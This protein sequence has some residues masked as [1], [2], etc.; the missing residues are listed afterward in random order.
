MQPPNQKGSQWGDK[1]TYL[2]SPR[3]NHCVLKSMCSWRW[4]WDTGETANS[5]VYNPFDKGGKHAVPCVKGPSRLWLE[6]KVGQGVSTGSGAGIRTGHLGTWHFPVI[7]VSH[8]GAEVQSAHP[9]VHQLYLNETGGKKNAHSPSG[10]WPPRIGPNAFPKPDLHGRII[11]F[12]SMF[13]SISSAKSTE[14]DITGSTATSN[15][16]AQQKP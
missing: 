9:A 7:G 6:K 12:T 15:R 4:P 10:M 11:I 2:S 5:Y 14:L 16:K 8:T 13:R 1:R 3:R